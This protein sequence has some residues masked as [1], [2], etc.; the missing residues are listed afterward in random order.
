[1]VKNDFGSVNFDY[2]TAIPPRRQRMKEIGFDQ[3][4]AL[5]KKTAKLLSVKYLSKTFLNESDKPVN[6]QSFLALKDSKI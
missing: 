4:G 1:M 2:I 6:K 3:S 5:A